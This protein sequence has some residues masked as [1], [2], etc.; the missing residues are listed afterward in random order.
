MPRFPGRADGPS[1]R[2]ALWL[3]L[4][5]DLTRV[6]APTRLRAVGQRRKMLA[7]ADEFGNVGVQ[8]GDLRTGVV[9]SVGRSDRA[10]SGTQGETAMDAKSLW[11]SLGMV[12]AATAA[13]VALA[14]PASPCDARENDALDVRHRHCLVDGDRTLDLGI[15]ECAS[16]SGVYEGVV[17]KTLVDFF[18]GRWSTDCGSKDAADESVLYKNNNDGVLQVFTMIWGNAENNYVIIGRPSDVKE[19]TNFND[20]II[21]QVE[22][23]YHKYQSSVLKQDDKNTYSVKQL[24]SLAEGQNLDNVNTTIHDGIYVNSTSTGIKEPPLHRCPIK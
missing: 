16:A 9:P 18:V 15:L 14:L 24:T 22:T 4:V 1:Q 12:I 2:H 10:D 7:L 17:D 5:R 13:A 11:R 20:M 23:D 6:S 3:G 21:M 8:A 19:L